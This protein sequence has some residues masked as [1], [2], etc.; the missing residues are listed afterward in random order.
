[1]ARSRTT[2]TAGDDAG[3]TQAAISKTDAVKATLAAGIV[4]PKLGVAHIKSTYGIDVSTA[5]FSQAKTL[6]KKK[7]GSTSAAEGTHTTSNASGANGVAGSVGTIKSLCDRLGT[8]QVIAIAK[9][10]AK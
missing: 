10:F 2:A 7:T 9:L 8:E 1:M 4:K 5:Q 3:T 6:A